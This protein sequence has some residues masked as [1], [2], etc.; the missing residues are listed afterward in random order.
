MILRQLDLS[1]KSEK[2]QKF[3]LLYGSNTGLIEETLD[4]T[5]K[6]KLSK[7][8][9]SYDESEVIKSIDEF[10]ENILN[11]SFFE[12][13]KLIIINR[14]SDKILEFIKNLISKNISE[15]TII[16]KTG[17]L[18]KRSKLRNFFEKSKEA[19]CVPFYDDNYQ[20]LYQFA[21][22]F[23]SENKIKI[24][25]QNINF[26]LEKS[27]KNRI[28]L[29]NELEKIKIFYHKKSFI[30]FEDILKLTTSSENYDIS[31]LTDVCL[32]K[33]KKKTINI[34]NENISTNESNILILKSFLFK[35]KRLKILKEEIEKKNNA[36]QVIS[37]H[38]PPIFWKDKDI[39]KKQL[40]VLSLKDIKNFI[41]RINELELLVKRNSDFSNEI[42]YDFIF[43]TVERPNNLI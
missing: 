24:S 5:L 8:I 38:K 22:N 9:Y 1:K 19:A 37:S 27:K 3:I 35:L 33:D 13:D 32:A 39:I 6:P 40:S 20:S 17:I 10:E 2:F 26:I 34:L 25:N 7:N 14:G 16:I 12:E 21:Q 23:L 4:K 41:K 28:F 29:K 36:D 11:K 30:E 43:E 15:I 31:E 42:T 18:E